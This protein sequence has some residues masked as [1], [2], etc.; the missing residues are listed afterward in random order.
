MQNGARSSQASPVTNHPVHP[1]AQ[2]ATSLTSPR[3]RR[4]PITRPGL[5]PLRRS[6]LDA[7]AVPRRSRSAPDGA[8]YVGEL[9]GFPFR[10]GSSQRLADQARSRRALV[11]GQQPDPT[12][13]CSLYSVRLHG[14]PGRRV[15]QEQRLALYVY[16]LAEDGVL[17]FEAG[18]D[19]RRV[20]AIGDADGLAAPDAPE[21]R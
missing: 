19:D 11:L 10:P 3:D 1:R 16:E 2:A 14:D 4:A 8:I 12:R 17:A 15:R 20:P 9:K 5:L 7:E 6:E 21:H 18:F 13:K